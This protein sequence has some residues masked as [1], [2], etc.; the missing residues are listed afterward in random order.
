MFELFTTKNGGRCLVLKL[1]F[2]FGFEL[3]RELTKMSATSNYDEYKTHVT[4]A[5]DITVD[6]GDFK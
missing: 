2:P 3:N 5:Y 6:I 1:D 4:L